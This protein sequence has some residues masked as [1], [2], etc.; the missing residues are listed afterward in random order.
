M[1]AVGDHVRIK[2]PFQR[3]FPEV[4]EVIRINDGGS[5]GVA[6][7]GYDDQERPGADFDEIFLEQTDEPLP[8]YNA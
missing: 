3:F 5:Y 6:L 4:Y 1:F 2:P 7:P 8:D